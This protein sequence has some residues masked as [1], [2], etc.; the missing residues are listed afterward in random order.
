V[1]AMNHT[2]RDFSGGYG[3]G[4][5]SL[6]SLGNLPK[7]NF[8]MFDGENPKPW[9][10][11]C[12]AYF[13]M[14]TVDPSVW[15]QVAYMQFIGPAARWLQSIEFRLS[16]ISW[17]EFC[18]L[19]Q[20]RFA[21]NQ[22]QTLLRRLFHIR[23]MGTVSSYVEEF[24]QLIDQLNA[25]HTMPDPLYYTL[26]FVEGL[27]D[28]IKAVVMLQ[29]PSDFDTATVLAQ[30]QEE[31]GDL[32]KKRDYRKPYSGFQ[33]QAPPPSVGVQASSSKEV[34]QASTTSSTDNK[35]AAMYAYR[36]AQGLCYKCGMTYSRGHR[37]ADTVQLQMVEE[38]WQMVSLP[39][40]E[41]LS[42]SEADLPLPTPDENIE[43]NMMLS[44]AAVKGIST[45]RTMRFVGHI[46]DIDVLSLLDSGSSHTFLTTVV[47][48]QLI[49]VSTMKTPVNVQVANGSQI[50]CCSELVDASWS[51][52][53]CTFRRHFECCPCLHMIS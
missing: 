45:P 21:K 19:I 20:D 7:L 40:T 9:Q 49:G 6:G 15:V 3:Q 1:S 39:E 24:A 38:L 42:S 12:E 37:C 4:P 46:G 47:A 41:M 34:K 25:Y 35:M 50:T 28:D 31:A 30:L 16:H 14:Y 26:K 36:K 52:G 13:H 53:G 8:P 22:H 29:C 5:P 51:I 27:K 17:G 10:S 33:H 23:Q 32:G 18:H 44:Q 11:R 48:D 43:V 2:Y